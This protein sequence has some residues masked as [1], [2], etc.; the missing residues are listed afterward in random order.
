MLM[1]R[2]NR[3]AAIFLLLLSAYWFL[4]ASGLIPAAISNATFW[5]SMAA[6]GLF[7]LFQIWLGFKTSYP[8]SPRGYP[9]EPPGVWVEGDT[10]LEIG[11]TVLA[12][13]GGQWWRAVIIEFRPEDS[14]LVRYV[15]WSAEW[16]EVHR[17]T[18]LQL[19]EYGDGPPS[20]IAEPD[21]ETAIRVDDRD[22]IQ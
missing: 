20:V 2:I 8:D 17:R 6:V 13:W 12:P 19:P 9:I 10:P 16:D 11:M 14:V 7:Y 15:A 3:A 1:H 21:V 18:S 5:P 22:K 4:G